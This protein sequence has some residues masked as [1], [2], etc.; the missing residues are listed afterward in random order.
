LVTS[1]AKEVTNPFSPIKFDA[2]VNEYQLV[3][4]YD[5]NEVAGGVTN[6]VRYTFYCPLLYNP[7]TGEKLS[8]STRPA[9]ILRSEP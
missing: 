5:T 2:E 3:Y 6:A 4:G 7:W 9:A 1:L 8:D